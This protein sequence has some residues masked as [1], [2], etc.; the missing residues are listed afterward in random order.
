MCTHLALQEFRARCLRP[1]LTGAQMQSHLGCS[2]GCLR[3]HRLASLT[4]LLRGPHPRAS[5]HTLEQHQ[6]AL[7]W[8]SRDALVLAELHPPFNSIAFVSA[9]LHDAGRRLGCP[10]GHASHPD[11]RVRGETGAVREDL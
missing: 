9:A 5:M 1:N 11:P 3:S 7:S 2:L 4:D 6:R 8:P 10:L